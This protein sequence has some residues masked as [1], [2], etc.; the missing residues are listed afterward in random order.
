MTT[1]LPGSQLDQL[2][3]LVAQGNVVP[4]IGDD[5]LL[6]ETPDGSR[7]VSQVLA[8]RLAAALTIAPAPGATLSDVAA[9]Y[10]SLGPKAKM[11]RVRAELS[12]IIKAEAGAW[13]PATSLR[14]LASIDAFR[15]F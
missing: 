11:Q 1:T 7:P 6:L 8:E 5:L 9:A 2:V 10:L 15:L 3:D 12:A 13:R 14:D 4:I